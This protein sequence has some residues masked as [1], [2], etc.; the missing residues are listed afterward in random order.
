MQANKSLYNVNVEASLKMQE[1]FEEQTVLQ[2]HWQK[3]SLE[4]NRTNSVALEY[5]KK[6]C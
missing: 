1:R 6:V 2:I 3:E 4:K 5:R